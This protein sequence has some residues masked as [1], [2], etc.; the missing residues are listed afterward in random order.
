MCR[1][2]SVSES[3]ACCRFWND[4]ETI[5]VHSV[6]FT[7]MYRN[8][9]YSRMGSIIGR[10][11]GYGSLANGS[12]ACSLKVGF[13]EWVRPTRPKR[14]SPVLVFRGWGPSRALGYVGMSYMLLNYLLESACNIKALSINI[15][16]A[17]TI[18]LA[19]YN[20]ICGFWDVE[21]SLRHIIPVAHNIF[22][23]FP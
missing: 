22:N 21:R 12:W 23:V 2:R 16:H 10:T 11:C 8:V 6:V 5:L 19:S 20:Q 1:P 18:I 7:V 15:V 17:L 9:S 4:S 14:E 13:R 3:A